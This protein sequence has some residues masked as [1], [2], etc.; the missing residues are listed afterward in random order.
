MDNTVTVR[1]AH[2]VI[3]ELPLPRTTKPIYL[4]MNA[5][6]NTTV[7]IDTCG[8]TLGNREV[9]DGRIHFGPIDYTQT[10]GTIQVILPLL[11]PKDSPLVVSNGIFT[12]NHA[13][14]VPKQA[15]ITPNGFVSVGRT[16]KVPSLD[17]NSSGYLNAVPLRNFRLSDSGEK[18]S[19]DTSLRM[20]WDDKFLYLCYIGSSYSLRRLSNDITSFGKKV[21][22]N[23]NE[24]TFFDDCFVFILHDEQTK[25][26]YEFV[27]NANGKLLDSQMDEANLWESRN[28]KWNSDAKIKTT[29]LEGKW[30][31]ELAIPWSAMHIKPA[32]G[33]L[34]RFCAGRYDSKKRQTST[35][36]P[37][38]AGYHSKE[39]FATMRLVDSVPEIHEITLEFLL[40]VNGGNLLIKDM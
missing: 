9:K 26:A 40:G 32:G 18:P 7:R 3:A 25:R 35:W 24:A 11:L 10:N 2:A 36:N 28:V 30:R 31:A 29:M 5:L 1:Y 4:S 37:G 27:C 33:I 38:K 23:D 22:N 16:S 39:R 21:V 14:D 34:F 13:A 15:A 8:T 20:L 19:E 6:G 17:D 12:T